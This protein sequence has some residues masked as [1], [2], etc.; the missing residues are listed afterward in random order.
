MLML[1]FYVGDERYALDS[2][3]VVEIVPLVALKKLHHAPEYV[4]GLFNY[5]GLVVPVIDI[6]HLLLGNSCN[7]HLSTRIIMVNY[8]SSNK[9]GERAITNTPRLLGLMAPRV[10]ETLDVDKNQSVTPGMVLDNAPYLGD[11]I[12]DASGMIQYLNVDYLLPSQF[13]QILPEVEIIP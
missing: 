10:T 13:N 8:F 9:N 5:R 3:K 11:I 7:H 12:T 2:K 6:C 4:A 1:L